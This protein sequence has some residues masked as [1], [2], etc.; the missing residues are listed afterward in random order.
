[1]CALLE[2][3]GYRVA[4]ARERGLKSPCCYPHIPLPARR[5]REGAWIE[6]AMT[7]RVYGSVRGRSREGAWIEILK[8]ALHARKRAVAPA[9]ERGLKLMQSKAATAA[10]VSRSR[11]GAWIEIEQLFTTIASSAASLPRGSVD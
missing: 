7:E 3:M 11:E 4:P 9:R 1:M 5:S 2:R 10:A 8:Y 6:M